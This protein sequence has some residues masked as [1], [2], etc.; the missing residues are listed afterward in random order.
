MVF[1]YFEGNADGEHR[2]IRVDYTGNVAGLTPYNAVTFQY[3]TR[4]DVEIGYV[5]GSKSQASQRLSQIVTYEANNV[6]KDY[7]LEYETGLATGKS[8]LIRVTECAGNG[9]CVNPTTFSWQEGEAGLDVAGVNTGIPNTNALFTHG[10]DVDGDGRTDLVYPSGLKWKVRFGGLEGF[11]PEV[12]TGIAETGYQY[13]RPLDFNADG[14]GDLLV[15]YANST[16][17][18]LVSTGQRVSPFAAPQNMAI[19]FQ[20]LS[21]VSSYQ[22]L[23]A[24][25]DGLPDVVAGN[26][27]ISADYWRLYLGSGVGFINQPDTYYRTESDFLSQVG[28]WNGDGLQDVFVSHNYLCGPACNYWDVAQSTA[29]GFEARYTSK[30][31][32]VRNNVAYIFDPLIVLFSI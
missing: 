10:F 13:A 15:P 23:D 20:P 12:D 14:K 5:L 24:N 17:H 9:D 11:G 3:E 28:D 26:S 27:G 16:W 32:T 21:G 6:V 2:I 8:R 25:G 4:P 19:P 29:S 7:G 31:V 30:K 1:T 22:I 18:V